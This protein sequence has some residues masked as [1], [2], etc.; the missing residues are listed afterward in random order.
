MP[1]FLALPHQYGAEVKV[2]DGP[3]F[4]KNY[5]TQADG[6]D[7][8]VITPPSSATLAEW[9]RS[10]LC[11]GCYHD[12]HICGGWSPFKS[13]EVGV[14]CGEEVTHYFYRLGDSGCYDFT[15]YTQPKHYPL[16]SWL[17]TLRDFVRIALLEYT[18]SSEQDRVISPCGA[19]KKMLFV[20]W[21]SA[22]DGL[23]LM[24]RRAHIEPSSMFDEM[25]REAWGA[26]VRLPVPSTFRFTVHDGLVQDT[27]IGYARRAVAKGLRV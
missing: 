8:F 23:T 17:Q 25:L 19:V 22:G 18:R 20:E 2:R 24:L 4:S 9:A 3:A 6:A 21:G 14:H 13:A 11:L 15:S 10:C 12:M 7:R 1:P 16:D 27:I 26:M 5:G